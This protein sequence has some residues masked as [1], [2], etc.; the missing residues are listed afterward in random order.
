LYHQNNKETTP[1]RAGKCDFCNVF[2]DSGN[3]FSGKI[4]MK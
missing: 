2:D 3:G 4:V 1:R